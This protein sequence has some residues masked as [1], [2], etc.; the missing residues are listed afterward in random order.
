MEKPS[1]PA[2]AEQIAAGMRSIPIISTCL[3]SCNGISALLDDWLREKE[4]G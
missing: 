4:G 2:A 3:S 1:G